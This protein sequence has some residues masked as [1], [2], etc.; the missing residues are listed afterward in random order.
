MVRIGADAYED[1]VTQPYARPMDFTGKPLKTMV[2]VG[3][4]GY[5]LDKTLRAW[6][7]RAIAFDETLPPQ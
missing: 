5:R 7:A 1:A 4:S 6:I 3:A 2:Y